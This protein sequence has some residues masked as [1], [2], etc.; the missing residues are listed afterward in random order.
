MLTSRVRNVRLESFYASASD[1]FFRR[2]VRRYCTYIQRRHFGGGIGLEGRDGAFDGLL[3][4]LVELFH[5]LRM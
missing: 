4:R 2:Q 3:E 5:I 1:Q